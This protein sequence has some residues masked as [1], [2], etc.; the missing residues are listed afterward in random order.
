MSEPSSVE[1]QSSAQFKAKKTSSAGKGLS[2]FSLLLALLILA[3]LLVGGWF[4]YPYYQQLHNDVAA[5]QRTVAELKANDDSYAMRTQQAL[6]TLRLQQQ[7]MKTQLDLAS[8]QLE[9]LAGADQQDWLFAE[10]EYLLRLANQRLS[11]ERD[12]HSALVMLQAADKV[13]QET[14]N[15]RVSPVRVLLAEEMLALRKAPSIDKEGAVLRL[16]ALQKELPHLPW[17]PSR[18]EVVESPAEVASTTA[19]PWYL[20]FWHKLTQ[21]L[22]DLVRVRERR[23]DESLPLSPK[24]QYYLQQNMYLMLEQAQIALL[25]EEPAL[26]QHS[27]ERV[28]Q[29]LAT[30][31]LST[32]ERTQA[33]LQAVQELRTWEINPERPSISGS[34]VKLQ[35]L[36]KRR[37]GG[38]E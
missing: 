19:E 29:W 33:V 30:Y 27:L 25:H 23:M 9:E 26:Y 13:L 8:D 38:Q 12:W 31:L 3:A 36:I 14:R 24:Q 34:L 22:L 15:P 17:L 35:E 2:L 4:G 28:E 10:A 32:N 18:L 21:G 16:Q 6:D 7:Q 37:R 5:L 20:R 1:K 11:L